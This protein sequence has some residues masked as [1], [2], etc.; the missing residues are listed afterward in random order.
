MKK[1]TILCFAATMFISGAHAAKMCIPDLGNGKGQ[2]YAYNSTS[3]ARIWAIGYGCGEYDGGS[4]A[5]YKPS[6]TDQA[7]LCDS[8]RIL[9]GTYGITNADKAC[10]CKIEYPVESAA[11]LIEHDNTSEINACGKVCGN[12]IL[13]GVRRYIGGMP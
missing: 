7:Q 6:I 1:S 4:S 5:G 8:G 2:S 13:Y 11:I 12:V 9:S 10:W 3:A